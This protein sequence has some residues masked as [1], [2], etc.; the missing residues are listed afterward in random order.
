MSADDSRE[1][2]TFG[3]RS[4]TYDR[5]RRL[6]REE[7]QSACRSCATALFCDE[8][9]CAHCKRER[10]PEGWLHRREHGDPWLGRLLQ[11]RYLVE[12][13][14]GTG[15]SARV[16]RGQALAIRRKVA[17]KIVSLRHP[18]IHRSSLVRRLHREIDAIS[19]LHNPHII[20]IYDVIELSRDHVAVI[21]EF[22]SGHTLQH[23]IDQ[24][25]PMNWRRA[26]RIMRQIANG[27]CE[28]HRAQMIHRDL[29]PENL[30]INQLPDGS[31]F[32]H[33]LDFGIV[34]RRQDADVSLTQGFLGTPLYASPEQFQDT[35]VD[36]RCDIYSLGGVFFFML[37]AQ[38]PFPFDE[39]YLV[40]F[41]HV[42]SQP[43]HLSEVIDDVEFPT[44]LEALVRCM[45]AKQPNQRP[46]DLKQVIQGLDRI[47]ATD[48]RPRRPIRKTRNTPPAMVLCR[49]TRRSTSL[50]QDSST[51]TTTSDSTRTTLTGHSSFAVDEDTSSA[52]LLFTCNG[53]PRKLAIPVDAPRS[54]L[55]M[56]EHS[57]LAGHPDGTVSR[58][59]LDGSCGTLLFE[60]PDRAS[61]TALDVDSPETTVAVASARG[62]ISL[63]NLDTLVESASLELQG[64]LPI[65]CLSLNTT[66]H[67]LA[68]GRKN[69]AVDVFTT[70]RRIR[71][72]CSMKLPQSPRA[73]CLS[74]D[75]YLLLVALDDGSLTIYQIPHV[76]SLSR[77]SPDEA[78]IV[79]VSFAPDGS[80]IALA[81]TNGEYRLLHLKNITDPEAAVAFR[82]RRP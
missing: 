12:A 81:T 59:G 66:S 39:V 74:P 5:H 62:R 53:S 16:Y 80:P 45:L 49:A 6:R 54:A 30:M 9:R 77:L 47:I 75:G 26:C 11:G 57:L 61:I 78:P 25:G 28:A 18:G 8:I 15:A 70:A 72:L 34:R 38:P 13:P 33:I 63:H 22:V 68:T 46:S 60:L 32:A 40:A 41:H 23:I 73:L 76:R 31:D 82:W 24:N 64:G 44:Q 79:D 43:P 55:A 20:S 10:P 21:M 17:I 37:S 52:P 35:S 56:S 50:Q 48:A 3:H 71:R 19:R 42:E 27:L 65:A 1:E 36:H 14:L 67:M 69:G 51:I 7:P 58:T 2:P 4:T 29:K